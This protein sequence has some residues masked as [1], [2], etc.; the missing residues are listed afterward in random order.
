MRYVVHGAGAVGGAIGFLLARAG[1]RVLLVARG[2]HGDSIRRHGLTLRTPQLGATL[3]IECVAHPCAAAIGEGDVVIFAVKAQD[4]GEALAE[5][6]PTVPVVCAQNGVT[7]EPTAAARGGPVYG[8]MSWIAAQHLEPGVIEVYGGTPSGAFR[9]G[10]HPAGIDTLAT[11]VATDL[12]G[13]GFDA[14]AVPDIQRWKHG[15]L[16]GNLGNALDAYCEAGPE[17]RPI[18]ARASFEGETVLRAAGLPFIPADE[19]YRDMQSRVDHR[20]T[21]D[22]RPRGG[23][24]TWQSATR[25]LPSEIEHLNG[26]ICRLGAELGVP[27]P[28]NDGLRRL[29]AEAQGPRSVT[30]A[31]LRALIG[32]QR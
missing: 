5:V 25:G 14:E 1:H 28:I 11:T 17:L 24:S 9:I 6:D 16:L 4:A 13:A 20:G 32:D 2:A 21:I 30:L 18:A 31:R 7:T 29:P 10:R 22:G 8:M 27:T 3:E 12:Q 26:W 19:L 23:G 15:K